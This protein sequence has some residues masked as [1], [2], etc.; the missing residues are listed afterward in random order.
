MEDKE[1]IFEYEH[2]KSNTKFR[3]FAE[4]L[5]KSYKYI[6]EYKPMNSNEFTV[7]KTSIS[8]VYCP[9]T[10]FK[11]MNKAIKSLDKV[12][13]I[14]LRVEKLIKP[15]YEKSVYLTTDTNKFGTES[16]YIKK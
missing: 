11:Y 9:G 12:S 13:I 3:L 5:G 16:T 6:Y 8:R 7:F 1:L 10:V 15:E 2:I 14:D 4:K